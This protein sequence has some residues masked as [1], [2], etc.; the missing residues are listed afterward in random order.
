MV[1]GK[2][3]VC[4]LYLVFSRYLVLGPNQNQNLNL[5]PCKCPSCYNVLF[6]NISVVRE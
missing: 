4:T 3:E 5:S 6:E 2:F 1:D